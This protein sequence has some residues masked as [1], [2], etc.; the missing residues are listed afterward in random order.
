M[1]MRAFVDRLLGESAFAGEKLDI[2][3]GGRLNPCLH[4]LHEHIGTFDGVD[5]FPQVNDH[6]TLRNR[7]HG[8][9]EDSDIPDNVYDLAFAYNVVE[10]IQNADTFFAKLRKVLKPGG[11]FWGI[12]P[13]GTHPFCMIVK[14]IQKLGI[15][16]LM[17]RRHEGANEYPAYYRLNRV[18]DI[19]AAAGR[20]GFSRLDAVYIPCLQWDQYFPKPL[21]FLP[22]LYD[23]V[24]G[25]KRRHAMLLLAYRLQ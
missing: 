8:T 1:Y 12:T 15:K 9:F 16:K 17:A 3:C 2:G 5:P 24:L 20:A 19:A 10:H 23:R 18:R 25:L 4:P 11:V 14:L 22:H 21:R 13:N 7:W 6:P